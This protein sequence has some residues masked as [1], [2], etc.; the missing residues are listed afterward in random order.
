VKYEKEPTDLSEMNSL[1]DTSPASSE[2]E[3][4]AVSEINPRFAAPPRSSEAADEDTDQEERLAFLRRLHRKLILTRTY[5]YWN[6][7]RWEEQT[8]YLVGSYDT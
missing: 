8:H 6:G 1:P 7:E 2:G 5:T 3:A 4:E